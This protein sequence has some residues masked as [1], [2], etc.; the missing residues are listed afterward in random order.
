MPDGPEKIEKPVDGAKW[1][2]FVAA[3]RDC[4]TCDKLNA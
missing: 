3:W 2:N 4:H 1:G